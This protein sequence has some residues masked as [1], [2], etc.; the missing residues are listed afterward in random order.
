MMVHGGL[1]LEGCDVETGTAPI[2]LIYIYDLPLD[3]PSFRGGPF[4][5]RW[6]LQAPLILL[7]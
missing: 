6:A 7:R 1:V 4:V 2:R 5:R 3:I